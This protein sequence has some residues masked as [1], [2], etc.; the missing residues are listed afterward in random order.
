MLI[1][2][3]S[4]QAS[5]NL[6]LSN[7]PDEKK[8]DNITARAAI[9]IDGMIFK[10]PIQQCTYNDV[11]S[12]YSANIS[13]N[14]INRDSFVN[15]EDINLLMQM[16][17]GSNNS[18]SN[19]ADINNDGV[20]DGFDAAELD[21][22]TVSESFIYLDDDND[23]TLGDVNTDGT[24]DVADYAMV[25][26]HVLCDIDLNGTYFADR[27]KDNTIDFPTKQVVCFMLPYMLAD[28]DR[29][30][31]VDAFDLFYLDKRIN[32]LI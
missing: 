2:G 28:V 15:E 22:T 30:S 13:R 9:N 4:I 29:D 6:V 8:D 20:V 11:Y 1:I 23:N 18:R 21:R 10:S 19:I 31:A 25:K 3:C 7:I 32:T 5:F 16:S 24:V 14:D 17:A 27:T 12:I 26:Q